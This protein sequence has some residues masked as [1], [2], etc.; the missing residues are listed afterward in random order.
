[1]STTASTS[2]AQPVS[3][4][5][6]QEAMRELRDRKQPTEW[7]LFSPDGKMWKGSPEDLFRALAPYH[8]LLKGIL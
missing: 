3:I 8:P 6:I 1:M 7:M 2:S 4:E 5:K